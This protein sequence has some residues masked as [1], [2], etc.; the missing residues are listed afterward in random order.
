MPGGREPRASEHSP[1][2]GSTASGEGARTAKTIIG[3][4]IILS[5]IR[6]HTSWKSQLLNAIITKIIYFIQL[7]VFLNLIPN[8]ELIKNTYYKTKACK[9]QIVCK[10]YTHNISDAHFRKS[11][12]CKNNTRKLG[13]THL[14]GSCG[15]GRELNNNQNH[16]KIF[17]TN[18]F[19]AHTK[20]MNK[21]VKGTYSQMMYTG[22]ACK[23]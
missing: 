22:R 5:M 16:N 15:S 12:V 20:K 7:L 8:S 10:E 3:S 19:S 4:K 2:G 17:E 11:S 14:T 1:V 9:Y 18:G 13:S 21:Q 23:N 6:P